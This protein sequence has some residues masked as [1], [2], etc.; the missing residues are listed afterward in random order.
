MN[1]ESLPL[2]PL[3]TALFPGGV[4]PLRVFEPRYLEMVR[5]CHE[6][7]VPFGVVQLTQGSEV[8]KPEAAERFERVGTLARIESIQSVQ[9]GLLSVVCHG[10]QRFDIERSERL[11][12]AL[13]VS[14]V[15]LIDNDVLLP[16]PPDL[17]NI[18]QTL[19]RVHAQLSERGTVPFKT[20]PEQ[21]AD[22]GWVA[23]R[24]CE[25]LPVQAELKQRLMQLDSPL[26]RLELV[27]DLLE[28]LGIN[29]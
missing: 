18:A 15:N 22:C 8:R 5:K 11:R 23:N 14:D 3:G 2:F 17:A 16:I 6:G 13:W 27:G 21:L 28:K 29:A 25:L 24:W 20:T 4:L 19:Q 12:N 1:L 26:M 9:A 7:G 10:V